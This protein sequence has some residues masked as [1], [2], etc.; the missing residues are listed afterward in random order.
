MHRYKAFISYSHRDKLAGDW[1][2]AGLENYRIP[3]TLIGIPGRDGLVP[4]K[5]FPVFRDREELPS[6][7]DLSGAI[8]NALAESACL[9]VI[10]S[11]NSARSRWVNEEIVAFRR[12]GRDDSILAVIVD[13]EPNATDDPTKN[14]ATECFPPALR[15]RL[16]PT[17]QADGSRTEPVAAD[18]RPQGDGRDNAL[19]KTVAGVLGIP[20]DSLKQREVEAERRRARTR[21]SLPSFLSLFCCLRTAL[22]VR[23]LA[24]TRVTILRW[25]SRHPASLRF[26]TRA[27]LANLAAH[28]LPIRLRFR[29]ETSVG[30]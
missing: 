3:R 26:S 16:G 10:C 5:L 25:S 24:A 28:D 12:L 1:L 8:Q 22:P 30:A 21:S 7:P 6:T 29:E 17:G 11:P 23:F 13:G 2:H 15:F 9:V 4:S 20:Y 18:A 14:P 27:L 19:L